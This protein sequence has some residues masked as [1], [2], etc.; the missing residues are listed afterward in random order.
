MTNQ[1]QKKPAE[2]GTFMNDLRKQLDELKKEFAKLEKSGID[3][4]KL[5]KPN[6][7]GLVIMDSTDP[8]RIPI[9][10]KD[11]ISRCRTMIKYLAVGE[12]DK[13]E[14]EKMMNEA[15]A[16]LNGKVAP[17]FRKHLPIEKVK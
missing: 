4:S 15:N 5:A 8:R 9:E 1:V 11:F 2:S 16:F 12:N 3:K 17:F 7:K 14:I 13:K 10:L 6:E